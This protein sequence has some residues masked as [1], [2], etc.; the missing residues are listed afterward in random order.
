MPGSSLDPGLQNQFK[1]SFKNKLVRKTDNKIEY[2]LG[3]HHVY[4]TKVAAGQQ[5]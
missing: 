3:I 2:I 1:P 4:T 5:G